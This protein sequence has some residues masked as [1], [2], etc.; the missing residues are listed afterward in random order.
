MHPDDYDSFLVRLRHDTVGN[1]AQPQWRGEIEHIQSGTRQDFA[2]LCMLL[3][4]L[5]CA[6]GSPP[7]DSQHVADGPP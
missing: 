5:R 6:T 2:T 7:P 3:A 4:F 1:D